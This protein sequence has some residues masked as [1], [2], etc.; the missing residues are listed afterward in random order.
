MTFIELITLRDDPRWVAVVQEA[1]E[2]EAQKLAEVL[3][4]IRRGE[5]GTHKDIAA[6][7]CAH[8]EQVRNWKRT[9]QRAGLM[10]E[11]KWTRRL[12]AAQRKRKARNH[13]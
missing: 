10:S 1:R 6:Y 4:R 2:Q 11:A 12:A 7:Y 8:P 13:D 9:A 5:F 3:T